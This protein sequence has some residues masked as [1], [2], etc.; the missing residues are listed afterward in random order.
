MKRPDIDIVR[1]ALKK[2]RHVL[3]D[4]RGIEETIKLG[5]DLPLVHL[6]DEFFVDTPMGQ[7]LQRSMMDEE[8]FNAEV[9]EPV[10]DEWVIH[11]KEQIL[12]ED[13]TKRG[14]ASN[15]TPSV[16][17]DANIWACF[18]NSDNPSLFGLGGYPKEVFED[19]EAS[20]G[21]KFAL[22]IVEYIGEPFIYVWQGWVSVVPEDGMS[23]H[24]CNTYDR[25]L[26]TGTKA[27]TTSLPTKGCEEYWGDSLDGMS[28]HAC[29]TYDRSLLTWLY[30]KYGDKHMVEVLPTK[31]KSKAEKRSS[32]NK[33]R[34][35]NTASGPKILFLDRMPTTQSQGTG[36]HA[37]PKP[38]RRRG[39]WKT[40]RHPRYRHHP[41]YQKKIYC[42]PSFV[43]PRQVSYE[44]NIYRLVEPL[45]GIA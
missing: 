23:A 16:A 21:V 4:L 25:S 41:Q 20:G 24:A 2:G 22:V 14:L 33:N 17:R 40:L 3:G 31:P 43:G 34:P 19:R 37:S 10:F 32:L 11:L 30:A 29:N 44:G 8:T 35:W 27:K 13:K 18:L 38:H 39:H 12:L 45:E 9:P 7:P 5:L 28:A 42:K 1:R 6:A 26:L 36:T 15:G